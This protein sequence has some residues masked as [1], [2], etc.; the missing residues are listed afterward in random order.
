MSA[1]VSFGAENWHWLYWMVNSETLLLAQIKTPPIGAK[2]IPMRKKVGRT[3]LGVRI[4]CQALRRCCLQVAT[5]ISVTFGH[6][7]LPKLT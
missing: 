5:A 7:A 6:E 2:M 3:V 4:G 1:N